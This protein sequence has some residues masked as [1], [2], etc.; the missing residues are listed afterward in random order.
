[1]LDGPSDLTVYASSTTTDVELTATL[2]VLA[3]DGTVVK[4]ADGV[5]LGSQRALDPAQSWYGANGTLLHP[6]HPFTEASPQPVVPG[7]TTRYDISLLANFTLIPAGDRIQVV[8]T[9]QPPA[10]FHTVLAPT[11]QESAEP[12]RRH[13][14]R[15]H[16]CGRPLRARPAARL[17][18][19]S[20]PRAPPT[21]DPS[22]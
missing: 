5:L 1:M 8:V 22:S 16:R 17:D 15:A 19:A 13:L 20:S 9:S 10:N 11:P 14:P 21:G 2:N 12:G 6:G 18:P 4:Q 3:S 7:R